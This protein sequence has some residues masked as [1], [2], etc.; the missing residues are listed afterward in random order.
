[1]V[2]G[3]A[4]FSSYIKLSLNSELAIRNVFSLRPQSVSM[5]PPLALEALIKY[6]DAG[7]HIRWYP[8]KL[9]GRPWKERSL[10]P[11]AAGEVPYTVVV[12]YLHG[13]GGYF[14][15]S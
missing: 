14:Q 13:G 15:V 6:Y 2:P 9:G 10:Q 11:V 12:M 5:S 8:E 1:M 3:C 4:I 7:P